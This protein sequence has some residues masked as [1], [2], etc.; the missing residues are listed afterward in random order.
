MSTPVVPPR[1]TR[2]L[3]PSPVRSPLNAPPAAVATPSKSK[4]PS[5]LSA[6]DVPPRPPSVAALPT[7]GQEGAEYASFDQLPPE[8]HGV[9]NGDA[10]YGT[11]EQTRNVSSEMPLH[12]P[13]ASL[14]QSTAK[15]RIETVTRTDSTQA[16]AAGIGKS[17]PDDDVHKTPADSSTSVDRVRRRSEDLTRTTSA[18]PNSLRPVVSA[19]GTIQS[20]SSWI[21]LVP[22]S[23]GARDFHRDHLGPESRH[24]WR[25]EPAR[26]YWTDT[27]SLI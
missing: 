5:T 8:A 26:E 3:D 16:A 14:P 21:C 7:L 17:K 13:K 12:A 9:S 6:E 2:K 4:P 18:D 25:G 10:A 20:D 15:T 11:P 1:P 24:L 19:S 27:I 22:E 23:S